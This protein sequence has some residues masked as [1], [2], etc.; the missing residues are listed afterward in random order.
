MK[1]VLLAAA[2]VIAVSV[3][4]GIVYGARAKPDPDVVASVNG[5]PITVR[6]LR[7][8]SEVNSLDLRGAE[9]AERAVDGAVRSK[10]VQLEASRLGLTASVAYDELL[11]DMAA[12]NAKRADELNAGEVVYGVP[13]YDERSYYSQIINGLTHSLK[14]E[15]TANGV[16]AVTDERLRD[17]YEE[18]RDLYARGQDE[19]ELLVLNIPSTQEGKALLDDVWQ[20]YE[21]GEDYERLYAQY[22]DG[23]AAGPAHA[24]K[25]TIG[26]DNAYELSKYQ[27]ELYEAAEAMA[28]GE[29]RVVADSADGGMLKLLYCAARAPGPSPALEDVK[30][31]LTLR[32]I[33]R[34]FAYRLDTL[35]GQADIKR[36]PQAITLMEE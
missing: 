14:N 28:P 8:Y 7:T 18:N 35:A 25:L 15:W 33:D 21:R 34:Q 16:I 19:I 32:Y 6:E 30:A 23:Q 31:E 2:A 9:A 27:G 20:R 24:E 13:S 11:A 36:Y 3:C 12:A 29:L 4:A 26:A 10:L 5:Y 1:T 22:A 17:F